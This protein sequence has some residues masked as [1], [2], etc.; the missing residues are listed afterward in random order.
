MVKYKLVCLVCHV[1]ERMP[2]L[3]RNL[4]ETATW[5]PFGNVAEER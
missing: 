5:E 2:P 3:A 1:E 4:M